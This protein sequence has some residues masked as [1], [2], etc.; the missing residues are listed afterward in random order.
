MIDACH[1]RCCSL[2]ALEK[3]DSIILRFSSSNRSARL[4]GEPLEGG[5][6]GI[7]PPGPLDEPE[8][9]LAPDPGPSPGRGRG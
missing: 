4:M 2:S 3:H 7:I 1:L 5:G 9:T 6:D 8:G